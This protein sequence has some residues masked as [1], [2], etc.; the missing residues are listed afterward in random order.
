M[1]FFNNLRLLPVASLLFQVVLS[2]S[3][4][5]CYYPD[6]KTVST[7]DV[8]C[9]VNSIAS[10]CCPSDSFCMGNGLCFRAGI[11]SRASCTDQDW[12]SAEC[13][14]YCTTTENSTTVSLTPCDAD[15]DTFVCGLNNTD[16]QSTEKTFEIDSGTSLVL[17]Q[18]EV[19][20]LIAVSDGSQGQKYSAGAMAGVALGLSLPLLVALI[21]AL[22]SL[23][24]EKRKNVQSSLYKSADEP[25]VHLSSVRP[26]HDGLLRTALPS[27]RRK[28]VTKTPNQ[29]QM[30]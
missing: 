29:A 22:V 5:T 1:S 7:V 2:A 30:T 10:S 14:A 25:D 3:S 23:R 19:A 20:A 16:C 17:R 21:V 13:A 8:P 6:A 28:S 26:K 9:N 18:S 24:K 27:L 4:G 15:T 11:T 12:N